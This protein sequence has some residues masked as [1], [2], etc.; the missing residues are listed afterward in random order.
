[1]KGK[2]AKRLRKLAEHIGA[3]RSPEERRALYQKLKTVHK[4]NK[5]A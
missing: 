5:K 2:S 4:A 1:M 3:N